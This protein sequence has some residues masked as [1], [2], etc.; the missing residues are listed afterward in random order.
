MTVG[1][2]F[3]ITMTLLTLGGVWLDGQF[4]KVAPLWTILGALFGIVAAM[5]NLIREVLEDD[6]KLKN[7]DRSAKTGSK[8]PGTRKP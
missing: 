6:R 5:M 3:A 4:P 1:T 8:K 2:Q 7:E